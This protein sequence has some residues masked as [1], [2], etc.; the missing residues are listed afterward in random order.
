MTEAKNEE[1]KAVNEEVEEEKKAAEKAGTA[2]VTAAKD[3]TDA[4]TKAC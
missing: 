4:K 1:V 2:V 3:A